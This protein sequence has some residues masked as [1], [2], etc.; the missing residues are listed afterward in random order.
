MEEEPLMNWEDLKFSMSQRFGS[1]KFKSPQE[2]IGLRQ[3][4]SIEEYG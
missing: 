3:R 1:K 4:G 2:L